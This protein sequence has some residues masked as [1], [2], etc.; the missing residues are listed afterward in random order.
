MAKNEN[1]EK[2]SGTPA[3][4]KEALKK[5]TTEMLVLFMLRQRPMYTYEM[6]QAIEKASKGVL[7]FNTLY[8]AI[9]RLQNNGYIQEA[10]KVMSS[11]NRVRVYFSVTEAGNRYFEDIK[12]EY[13]S[14]TSIINGILSLDG[15]L[16]EQEDS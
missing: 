11:D 5:A 16:L 6:M 8:L 15:K 4:M 7:T 10:D 9:Y 3:S 14:V 12:K 1:S 13:L 2:R